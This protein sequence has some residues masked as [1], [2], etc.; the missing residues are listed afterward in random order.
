MPYPTEDAHGLKTRLDERA[1]PPT[2]GARVSDKLD[3]AMVVA[4]RLLDPDAS[5]AVTDVDEE[6]FDLYSAL[7]RAPASQGLGQAR[8]PPLSLG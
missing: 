6:L 2:Q 3:R 5:A 4:G 7:S 1:L 8:K